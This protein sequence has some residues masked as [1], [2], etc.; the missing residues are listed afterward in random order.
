M[1]PYRRPRTKKCKWCRKTIKIASRGPVPTYCSQSCKQRAYERRKYRGPMLALIEDTET[2]KLR[3]LIR[4]EITNILT[5]NGVIARPT[6]RPVKPIASP[7]LR[8]VKKDEAAKES[9][10]MEQRES[11]EPT[12]DT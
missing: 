7:K 1:R 4:N 3:A 12:E 11:T 2:V 8:L 5:E 9:V 10:G 6:P